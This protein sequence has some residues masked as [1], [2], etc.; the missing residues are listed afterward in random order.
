ML[1]QKCGNI[2]LLELQGNFL[3]ITV[4]RYKCYVI[5]L[6]MV[7]CY[8]RNFAELIQKCYSINVLVLRDNFMIVTV[9]L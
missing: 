9:L 1:I 2:T 5:T 6:E 4:L 3:N 8:S 7:Q